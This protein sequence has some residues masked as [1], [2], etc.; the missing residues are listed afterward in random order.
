MVAA[1]FF[2]VSLALPNFD[3]DHCGGSTTAAFDF[4]RQWDDKG[5]RLTKPTCHSESCTTRPTDVDAGPLIALSP[6]VS[7]SPW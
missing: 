3:H 4:L 7:I 6:R 2:H 5:A 1:S